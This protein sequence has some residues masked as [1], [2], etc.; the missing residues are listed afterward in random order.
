MFNYVDGGDDDDNDILE[1]DR[2]YF[3]KYP[4]IR[5]RRKRETK[6]CDISAYGT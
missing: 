6:S 3:M 5:L 1:P 4:F 2:I